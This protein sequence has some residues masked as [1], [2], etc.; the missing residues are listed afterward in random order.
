[1]LIAYWDTS[2]KRLR[3]K[4]PPMPPTMVSRPTPSGSPAATTPAKMRI[5][6]SSVT[7]S[8]TYSA[9]WRS[10][11]R[12]LLNAWFTGTK[13]VPVTCRELEFTLLRRSA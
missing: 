9:R 4:L 10:A 7:G 6:R 1:M 2:V 3:K 8:D 5:S 13:P 12:V 11:S